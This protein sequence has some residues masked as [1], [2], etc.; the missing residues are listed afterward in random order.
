[1][2]LVDAA[3]KDL[4]LLRERENEKKVFEKYEKY[5]KLKCT[6]CNREEFDYNILQDET[7]CIFC[8][9]VQA[10]NFRFTKG[11]MEYLPETS[12]KF[13]KSIY[14]HQDYLNRKLDE[15]SCARVKVKDEIFDQIVYILAGRRATVP[16]LKRILSSM[17][18]KQKFLQ[19]PTILY[20]LYPD[21]YPPLKLNYMTRRKLERMF[22]KYI[23][24]FFILK[25]Q[26][27]IKRKNLLNYNFVFNK[28]FKM[29]GMKIMTHYFILPKGRKTIQVHHEI[30][31]DIVKFN[32]W[33]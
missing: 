11:C 15:L 28:L 30:W 22:L 7:I 19:I 21:K 23:D 6:D 16:L 18:M 5:I 17:G 14:K 12:S 27:K 31:N 9:L 13:K 32:K 10:F 20:T 2:S 33:N 29:L 3:W 26:G 25:N 1:M 24:T 8:G 4:Y